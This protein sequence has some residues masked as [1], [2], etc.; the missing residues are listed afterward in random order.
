MIHEPLIRGARRL[1]LP[2]LVLGCACLASGCASRRTT[3]EA[4]EVQRPVVQRLSDHELRVRWPAQLAS[5]ELEVFAGPSPDGD[6][7]DAP[8]ARTTGEEATFA[9]ADGRPLGLDRPVYF[10]LVPASG[11][12]S[13]IVS[14]RRLPLQGADNF[15]DLGGYLTSDGQAVR[16][17]QI[18][19][20]NELGGLSRADLRYLSRMG[21][22]LVCD[23]RTPRER[24][25]RPDATLTDA[26]V[27]E[28]ELPVEQQGIEAEVVRRQILT[29][30][31]AGYA[32][33]RTLRAAYAAFVTEHSE[34]WSRLL[35]RLAAPDAP[36]SVVHCTAGK[37]RTGFASALVLLALGVPQETVFEDYMLT[38]RY[39]ED[40]RNFVLRW[41]PLASLFRTDRDDLLPLLEARRSYL[42]T[43]I[44]TMLELY[45]SVDAYLDQA[46]G[47]GPE[48]R[49][50]LRK[51]LLRE[52]PRDGSM[53][54]D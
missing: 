51:R 22:K 45:G 32:I 8:L 9:R 20:S 40:Y 30:A 27:L 17:G 24:N 48:L 1:A 37:D 7:G 46:L 49:Q 43:S 6:A 54:G 3:P 18:F 14:E 42:Q 12:P 39:R 38:N 26:A 53:T 2:V 28:L 25:D 31:L 52:L 13:S 10:E 41:V 5:G 19:R 44:D 23:L 34:A 21:V 35:H 4:P 36:P 29:G 50:A 33:E 11:Q 15:R 47:V 16:W